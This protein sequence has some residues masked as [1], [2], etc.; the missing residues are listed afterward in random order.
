MDREN[1]SRVPFYKY[2]GVFLDTNFSFKKHVDVSK[3]LICHKLHLLSKIR[4]HIYE[5]T[6]TRIFQAMIGPLIDYGDIVYSGTTVKNLD[7]LQSLQ[8]RG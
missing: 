7:K 1:L 8:N 4:K 3:K 5:T 2:L 6:A